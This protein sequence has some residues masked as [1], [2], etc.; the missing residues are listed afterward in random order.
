MKN[1]T[2]LGHK[3]QTESDGCAEGDE[4]CYDEVSRIRTVFDDERHR[5]P[6]YT[7]DDHIV[8]THSDVFGVIQSSNAD[9]T[10]L[11]S[12]ETTEYLVINKFDIYVIHQ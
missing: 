11:P 6:R 4:Q 3:H 7:H 9:L 10:C 1:K 2:Y 8:H 12:K 5:N